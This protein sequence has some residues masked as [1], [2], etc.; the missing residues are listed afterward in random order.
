M[1]DPI[2]PGGIRVIVKDSEGNAVVGATV[3]IEPVLVGGTNGSGVTNHDGVHRFEVTP[4]QYK[5]NL[6]PPSQ[7]IVT[8]QSDADTNAELKF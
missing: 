3:T 1:Q 8:A 7:V 5:V 6:T 2:N 4:G